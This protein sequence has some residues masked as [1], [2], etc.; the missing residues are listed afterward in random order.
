MQEAHF[1]RHRGLLRWLTVLS[2]GGRFTVVDAGLGWQHAA[3]L[4]G[5][6]RSRSVSNG[7]GDGPC[8]RHCVTNPVEGVVIDVELLAGETSL[9]TTRSPFRRGNDIQPEFHPGEP[10]TSR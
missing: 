10:A 4:P 7:N 2:A 3:G 1:D 6:H 5:L 9:D 8:D